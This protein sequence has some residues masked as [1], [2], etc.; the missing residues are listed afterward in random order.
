MTSCRR[1]RCVVRILIVDDHEVVRQGLRALLM[2]KGE[3]EICGEACDGREAIAKAEQL[4]PD[5]I[6]M[7]ISMPNLNG[8]DA[9]REIL[10]ILPHTQIVVLSQH[11]SPEMMRQALH[12]GAR[13]YI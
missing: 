3:V 8:I 13:G 5:A 6:T 2:A 12:A 9:T 11:D 1:T 7:D 4:R 10:R